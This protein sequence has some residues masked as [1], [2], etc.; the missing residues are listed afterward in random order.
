MS[1]QRR[2][3]EETTVPADKS[4]SEIRAMLLRYGVEQFGIMEDAQQAVIGFRYAGRTIKIE[5]PMPP[6][7][8][9]QGWKSNA[10]MSRL[11]KAWEQEERRLWRVVREWI[12][13]QLEAVASGF[14]TFA[15]VFLAD[16]VIG[17]GQTF[18]QWAEPQLAEM[19]RTG[20]MPEL[21]LELPES[22]AVG[23]LQ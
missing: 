11:R 15:A 9:K 12:H 16:T 2:P 20:K 14:R 7:L 23:E 13:G 1:K 4:K 8:P 3:F 21:L 19:Q 6:P 22:T 18:A 10:E 17:R 5:V